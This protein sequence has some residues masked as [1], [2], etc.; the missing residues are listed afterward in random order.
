VRYSGLYELCRKIKPVSI[1]EVGTH[2]GN[3]AIRMILAADAA[4]YVGFDLFEDATAETDK[5]EFNVKKHPRM[6]DVHSM[7]ERGST[8]SIQLVKGNTRET[9]PRFL[10]EGEMFDFAF[11]DGGHSLETIRSDWEC[12]SQMMTEDGVVVFDDY[13]T[14]ISGMGCNELMESLP[15]TVLPLKDRVAGGGLVQ[16]ALVQMKHLKGDPCTGYL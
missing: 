14:G 8:A 1:L 5:I 2:A 16:M 15:H 6:K 10:E 7:L 3:S 9:L 12:V 11:I 4:R 13:Y